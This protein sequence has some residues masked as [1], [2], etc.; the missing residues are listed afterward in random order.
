MP[1][2]T[3][4]VKDID[5]PFSGMLI[6]TALT[7]AVLQFPIKNGKPDEDLEIKPGHYTGQF[8]P[9]DAKKQSSYPNYKLHVP[10]GESVDFDKIDIDRLA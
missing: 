1:K 7:G 5:K 2:I 9:S 6:L 4:T 10:E 8:V 3:G